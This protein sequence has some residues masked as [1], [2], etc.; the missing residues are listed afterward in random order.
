MH[1]SMGTGRRYLGES[2]DGFDTI[3][4][5]TGYGHLSGGQRVLQG[6]PLDRNSALCV[7]TEDLELR[8]S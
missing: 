1:K 3:Y 2:G 4:R 8:H 6:A 5:Q 7:G